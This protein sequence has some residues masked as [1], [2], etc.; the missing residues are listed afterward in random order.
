[1]QGDEVS[2]HRLYR[3][4]RALLSGLNFGLAGSILLWSRLQA[5]IVTAGPG[6]KQLSASPCCQLGVDFLNRYDHYS[7][8]LIRLT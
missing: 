8:I 1:M 4:S 5:S 2:K 6:Y 3:G 7:K